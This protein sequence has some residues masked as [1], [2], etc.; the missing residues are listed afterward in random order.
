M[1]K[2]SHRRKRQ[3]D[4]TTRQPPVQSSAS[5]K[6]WL[7]KLAAHGWKYWL[8]VVVL[9]GIGVYAGEVFEEKDY[10]L[11]QRY[12]I[13]QKL[14]YLAPWKM[15]ANHTAA[16]LI[17]DKEYWQDL[18][19]RTPVS[20]RYL[21]N[22]IRAI[23]ACN[24]RMIAIDFDL[25]IPPRDSQD[26]EL[27]EAIEE[28][29]QRRPVVLSVTLEAVG[30]LAYQLQPQVYSGHSFSGVVRTGHIQ[31]YDD[32]RRIPVGLRLTNGQPQD[33]FSET[34][35][36]LV[37]PRLLAD[38]PNDEDQ[39]FTVFLPREDFV[40]LDAS[41]AL[42]EQ[43]KGPLNKLNSRIVIVSGD[44]MLRNIRKDRSD[45]QETPVGTLTGSLV[46]ANYVE[47]LLASRTYRELN[48][49]MALILEVLLA[50]VLV[51]LF[52]LHEIS[53]A[54][55]I[56][57]CFLAVV[58]GYFLLENVGRYYDFY[59]PLLLL[60]LH[61]GFEQVKEMYLELRAKEV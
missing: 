38:F 16:V 60:A 39:P 42:V 61:A 57:L 1:P 20:R 7:Q 27:I 10:A 59:F 51:V 34:I 29:S 50:G 52:A 43:H 49:A 26:A 8:L 53:W 12:W 13:Y 47:A 5:S 11:R 32:I 44:W 2:P 46:Q 40:V 48:W 28:V 33:S 22:L 58:I 45:D 17:G 30:K 54:K 4:E 56:G 37:D 35:V 18:E 55:F 15:R 41:S 9:I 3:H 19:G 23:D 36:K 24:P 6:T 21:A 25:S 14:L 31:A